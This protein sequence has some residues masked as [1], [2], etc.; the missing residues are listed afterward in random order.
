MNEWG[1]FETWG[2]PAVVLGLGVIIG[3]VVAL[4]SR[5]EAVDGD[6]RQAER[7]SLVA[8]KQSLIEQIRGLDAE[9]G[10]NSVA[11]LATRKDALIDEAAAV[12]AAIDA[13]DAAPDAAPGDA[14]SPA[15]PGAPVQWGNR[16]VWAVGVVGFFVLLGIGLTEFTRPRNGGSMTGGDAVEATNAGRAGVGG[17]ASS[18]ARAAASKRL[19]AAEAAATANPEDLGALNALTFE[20]LLLRDFQTAMDTVERARIIAPDDPDVQVHLGILQLAVGMTERAEPAFE[21]A[22][23]DQPDAGKP[24][25]WLGLLQLQTE[26]RELAAQTLTEALGKGLREDEAGFAQSL[27]LEARQPA[28]AAGAMPAGA[29]PGAAPG[30]EVSS[31]PRLSGRMTLAD[32]VEADPAKRVFLIVHRNEAGKGPPLA[33]RPLSAA[34]L[35]ATFTLTDADQMMSKGP[36]PEQVWVFARLDADGVAGSGPGDLESAKLGP[37]S[38]GTEGVELVIG[39][40]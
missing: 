7:E 29:A 25:L 13:L 35:P 28:P 20:A 31:A 10:R 24:R 8:R 3:V 4:R 39:A 14:A 21:K 27:L 16:A 2:P 37:L 9:R 26:R 12:L 36:W 11:E 34:E 40:P 5:G 23:A 15:A 22:A 6:P 30:A 38:P 33:V 19:A 18:P 1:G 32:G 17:A